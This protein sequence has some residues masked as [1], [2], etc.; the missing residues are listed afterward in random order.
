MIK[1]ATLG[2][3]WW[4]PDH[5]QKVSQPVPSLLGV[6]PLDRAVIEMRKRFAAVNSAI[7]C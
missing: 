1:A 7:Y 4:R 6:D 2:L 5:P 3:G